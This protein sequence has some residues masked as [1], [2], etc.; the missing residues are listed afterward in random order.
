MFLAQLVRGADALVRAGRR[1]ADVGEHDIGLGLG[2]RREQP[3][4]VLGHAGNLEVVLRVEETNHALAHQV[5]VFGD[6][7]ADCHRMTL[8]LRPR[9]AV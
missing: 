2:D 9:Q 5:A 8:P 1:H 6:D 4:E 3:V 7:D